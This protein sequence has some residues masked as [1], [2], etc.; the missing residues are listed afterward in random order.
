MIRMGNPLVGVPT[1]RI[2]VDAALAA[3][4]AFPDEPVLEHDG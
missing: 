2:D 3:V 1:A 4:A